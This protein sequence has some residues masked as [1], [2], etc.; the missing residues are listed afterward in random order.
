LGASTPEI[1][2]SLLTEF[3]ITI[4]VASAIA[5]PLAYLLSRSWLNTFAF[6]IEIGIL[7]FVISFSLS[8]FLCLLLVGM[9]A[10]RLASSNLVDSFRNN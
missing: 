7:P 10:Y 9:K 4:I 3:I 5:F 6:K 8:L 2:R 1:I